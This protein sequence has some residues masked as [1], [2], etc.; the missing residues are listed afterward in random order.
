MTAQE[1]LASQGK[2]YFFADHFEW[3][4]GAMSENFNNYIFFVAPNQDHY[5]RFLVHTYTQ[6]LISIYIIRSQLESCLMCSNSAAEQML[7][8]IHRFV[9]L[10]SLAF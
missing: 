1:A 4:K 7:R 3:I 5:T 8:L 6:I 9:H 10:I 2:K